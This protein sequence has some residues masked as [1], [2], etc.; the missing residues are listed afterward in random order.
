MKNIE[1][2]KEKSTQIYVDPIFIK[3]NILRT[4]ILWDWKTRIEM[5]VEFLNR[6]LITMDRFKIINFVVELM[7]RSGINVMM[8]KQEFINMQFKEFPGL[9]IEMV[10]IDF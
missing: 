6:K 9:K 7:R 5:R 10:K 2:E 3:G 8:T 1:I 4:Y